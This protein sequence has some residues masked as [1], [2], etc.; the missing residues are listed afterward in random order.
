MNKI[1]LSGRLTADGEVRTTNNNNKE[2]Y[3]GTIAVK[4]N[5]KNA[6]NEYESDFFNIVLWQPLDYIKNNA[7]KGVRVLVE[8]KIQN[9]SYNDKDNNKKYITEIIAENMEIYS[10][11]KSDTT[12]IPQ[13]TKTEYEE[14]DIQI[15]DTDLPF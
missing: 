9:R 11:N 7:K 12:Q 2:V 10:T 13:N 6:N 5:Y 15:D 8:G 4:R 1:I 14:K 3:T